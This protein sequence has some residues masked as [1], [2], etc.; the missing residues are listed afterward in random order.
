M[1][2]FL[3]TLPSLRP[4]PSTNAGTV[5]FAAYVVV[6]VLV[7]AVV[8]IVLI[9]IFTIA[10]IL[11]KKRREGLK[12]TQSSGQCACSK[13]LF[14]WLYNFMY[15]SLKLN[16]WEFQH[17]PGKTPNCLCMQIYTCQSRC[18]CSVILPLMFTITHY[19]RARQKMDWAQIIHCTKAQTV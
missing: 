7:I 14:D 1:W 17:P 12:V 10:F 3:D 6:V 15:I 19:H 8:V 2:Y 18:D 13:D 5:Q 16:W 11:K 9:V 4:S